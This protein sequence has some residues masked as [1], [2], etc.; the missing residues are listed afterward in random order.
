MAKVTAATKPSIAGD[1][2]SGIYFL[3]LSA[4]AFIWAGPVPQQPPIM[5]T[6]AKYI[7]SAA[8]AKSSG[9]TL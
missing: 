5:F 7:L 4:N 6:P 1:L 3:S 8:A 2:I 9:D